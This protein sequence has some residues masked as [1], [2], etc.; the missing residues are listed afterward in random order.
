MH[1]RQF[2]QLVLTKVT[3]NL[4]AEASKSY[5]SYLWWLIEPAFFV[6]IMYLVF[7]VFLARGGD[8]FVVFLVCGNIPF[9]WFSKS[10]LN[11]SNSVISGKG[12]ISQVR[13]NKIFFPLVTVGQD[14]VK[15]FAVF[16]MLIVFLLLTG[17]EPSF[18]WVYLIL[19]IMAQFVFIVACSL[20]VAAVVPV[21]PDFRYL[22]TTGVQLLMYGSGIF[23]SYKEVLHPEHRDIFLLN[24][25]ASLIN[26]YRLI[27]LEQSPP[28]FTSLTFVFFGCAFF[29][30]LM[31]F[32][33]N[34]YNGMYSKL[35]IE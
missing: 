12:L 18:N 15:Q 35:V 32:I 22:V 3:L 24:P 27:F 29:I 31:F 7:G 28:N 25:M 8:G 11:A 34:K 30:M 21:F 10:V 2:S 4:K 33:F 13:I 16:I 14:L 20:F 5:L 9:L 6:V 1:F 23:Y 26:N 19:V 17:I